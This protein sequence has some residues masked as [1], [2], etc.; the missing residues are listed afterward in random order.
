VQFFIPELR[1][2][3][4][5]NRRAQDL[6]APIIARRLALEKTGDLKKKPV[7]SMEWIRDDASDPKDK[8]DPHLHAILQ[9]ILSALS[10]NTTS[11]LLTN[12]IFNLANWPEYVPLIR[13]EIETTLK[14][15]GGEW[16]IDSMIKL[17]KLDSFIKETLRHSGHLTCELI[18]PPAHCP[19]NSY[20]TK[21]K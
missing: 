20:L 14:E 9:L 11:Q 6:L 16:T 7:D 8:N 1:D 21:Q 19:F 2:V 4:R 17:E 12:C 10:V 5:C 3:W 13:E 18:S 15:V